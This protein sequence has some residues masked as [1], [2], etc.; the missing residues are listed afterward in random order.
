LKS[1]TLLRP[2]QSC[3]MRLE[4]SSDKVS[5]L[6]AEKEMIEMDISVSYA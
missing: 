3:G 2:R 1:R 4:T 5:S 6:L